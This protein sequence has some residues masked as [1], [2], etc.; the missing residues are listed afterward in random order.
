[1]V[2]KLVEVSEEL[3]VGALKKYVLREVFVN[4]EHVICLR[5][6]EM[7]KRKLLEN[8]LP[9]ELDT[10]QEFTRIQ[11]ASGHGGFNITVVGDPSIVEEKLRH[12]RKV[13]RG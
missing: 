3:G 9:S 5:P 7:V 2:V 1:M 12:S 11:M 10:R 13:L 6:D 4:P 8:K